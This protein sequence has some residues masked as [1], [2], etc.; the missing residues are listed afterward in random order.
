MAS[1]KAKKRGPTAEH[2]KLTGDWQ[3]AVK[4]ALKRRRPADGWPA[5]PK[6]Y[7]PRKKD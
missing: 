7:K 6:R 3:E 2:V 5:P 1:K 4:D